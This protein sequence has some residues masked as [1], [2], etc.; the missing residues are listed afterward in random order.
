MAEVTGFTAARM[1]EIENTTIVSGTVEN[2][3]LVLR[4]RE[5]E[6]IDAGQVLGVV[7]EFH[8]TNA[9]A[10]RPEGPIVYWLGSADPVNAEPWDFHLKE[11][12]SL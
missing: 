7:R 2:G 6:E 8:G 5:G 1:L 12:I 9:N 11:D 4:T 10:P 3:R